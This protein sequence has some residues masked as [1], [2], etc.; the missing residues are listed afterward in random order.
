MSLKFFPELRERE[1]ESLCVCV[2]VC[3]LLA[4]KIFSISLALVHHVVDTVSQCEGCAGGS[5]LSK[6]DHDR[7]SEW[8]HSTGPEVS[9][10]VHLTWKQVLRGT[11]G[12]LSKSV[13]VY[14]RPKAFFI[15]LAQCT[16]RKDHS[17]KCATCSGGR[18]SRYPPGSTC[19]LR[20]AHCEFRICEHSLTRLGL[21]WESYFP[22]CFWDRSFGFAILVGIWPLPQRC[23]PTLS[24]SEGFLPDPLWD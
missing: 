12:V 21:Q 13:T 19:S 16:S 11:E 20:W 7:I 5:D 9:I 1:R 23:L 6:D 17:I 22:V 10:I 8:C 2:F 24:C 15:Y 3:M 14:L 18:L 4:S